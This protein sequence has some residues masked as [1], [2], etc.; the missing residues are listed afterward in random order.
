MVNWFEI[1]QP[2][3]I[4]QGSFGTVSGEVASA[5]RYTE[6]CL[7]PFGL[8]CVCGALFNSN[9]V[10]DWNPTYDNKNYEPQYLPVK[11]DRKSVV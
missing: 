9:E 3:M 8:E 1:K 4:G 6:C 11:V 7:S 2:M 10:V 5:Q